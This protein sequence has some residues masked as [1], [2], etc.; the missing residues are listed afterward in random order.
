METVIQTIEGSF[1]VPSEK[2][3]ALI[4]WLKANAVQVG[5]RPVYEIKEEGNAVRQLISE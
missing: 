2:H 5:S 1:V 4:G 3:A